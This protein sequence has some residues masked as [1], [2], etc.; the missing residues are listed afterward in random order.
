MQ[1][2]RVAGIF[3]EALERLNIP[4]KAVQMTSGIKQSSFYNYLTGKHLTD[5]GAMRI[6]KSMDDPET[7]YEIAHQL[8]QILPML[9][10]DAFKH[11]AISVEA[12]QQ[13]EAEEANTMYKGN[14]IHVKLATGEVLSKKEGK[15]FDDYL[16]QRLQEWL[17]GI[18]LLNYECQLRG[19]TLFEL[20]RLGEPELVRK[21]YRKRG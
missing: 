4:A 17:L 21:H 5:E 7:M 1:A 6:A 8:Y 15:Q 12:Y 16:V 11:D 18:T 13:L 9:N 3:G 20:Y 10:G 19:I 2:K 14:H